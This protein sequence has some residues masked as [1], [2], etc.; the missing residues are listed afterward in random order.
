MEGQCKPNGHLEALVPI[1]RAPAG[2]TR[3]RQ[4]AR[5]NGKPMPKVGLTLPL[6]PTFISYAYMHALSARPTVSRAACLSALLPLSRHRGAREGILSPSR[7]GDLQR[8]AHAPVR[9][10]HVPIGPSDRRTTDRR[11]DG[12][13]GRQRR[14]Y[15]N[16]GANGQGGSSEPAARKGATKE[17]NSRSN[18]VKGKLA[19]TDK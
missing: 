16:N 12:P 18:V 8:S 10:L 11:T 5:G 17:G 4:G 7:D 9:A 19:A 2:R 6:S 3:W 15:G 1:R 13:T 14:K